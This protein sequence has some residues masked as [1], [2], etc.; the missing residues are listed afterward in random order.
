MKISVVIPTYNRAALLPR[1]VA[2]IPGTAEAEIIIVDD[3]STD[4]TKEVVEQLHLHDSRIAYVPLPHNAGVNAARNAGM[5]HAT[6]DWI[7]FLD[8]DDEYVSGGFDAL[9][10]ILKSVSPEVDVV[11][12]MTFREVAG[13]MEPRGFRIGE[14]W[15]RYT[16]SYADLVYK[17]HIRGDIHY[18][19]RRSIFTQG[20]RFAVYINGFE[21]A[22]YAKLAKDGKHFLYLNMIIDRRYSTGDTHLSIEPYKRW[23]RQFARAYTEF[24]REHYEVLLQRPSM[25]RDLYIRIGNSMLRSLDLRGVFW[26]MKAFALRYNAAI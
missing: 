7:S 6:G 16:P 2:S 15:D 11:G 9:I 17:E 12:C 21:S 8:S 22:F 20:Y 13:V 14:S 10:N 1:A 4:H 19:I 5:E 25:L 3:G 18:C 23:P 26:F 24:V